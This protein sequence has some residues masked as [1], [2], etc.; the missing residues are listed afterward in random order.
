[1]TRLDSIRL[2]LINVDR[3]NTRLRIKIPW[4]RNNAS[5][6]LYDQLSIEWL[7]YSQKI[8]IAYMRAN[9]FALASCT[10]IRRFLFTFRHSPDRRFRFMNITH[11]PSTCVD[12][13]ISHNS[14]VRVV[15][16]KVN[17]IICYPH[18]EKLLYTN[19]PRRN[20][21]HSPILFCWILSWQYSS[22][23][24]LLMHDIHLRRIIT[25]CNIQLDIYWIES[26]F[27]I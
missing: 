3:L 12:L 15:A 4:N 23:C 25:I 21:N 18:L 27:R 26:Q 9:C 8:P 7:P 20:K 5:S 24:S 13:I 11:S 17:I 14:T 16:Y 1:M 10:H 22:E 2:H 6:F 19:I